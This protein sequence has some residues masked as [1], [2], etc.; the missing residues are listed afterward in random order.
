MFVCVGW[1][2]LYVA[3]CLLFS[4]CCV[5][6]VVRR[7]VLWVVVCCVLFVGSGL[8]FVGWS[9][10]CVVRFRALFVASWR[11]VVV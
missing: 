3:G 8:S 5:V 11:L 6:Y 10:L 2:W 7:R 4:V 9:V 1:W